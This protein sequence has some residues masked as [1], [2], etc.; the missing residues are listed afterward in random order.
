MTTYDKA[1]NDNVIYIS[2]DEDEIDETK[3]DNKEKI[4]EEPYDLSNQE[5]HN[6]LQEKNNIL[7]NKINNL[8]SEIDSLHP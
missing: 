3:V 5:I 2:D 6:Q 7:E 4:K 1:W 8:L